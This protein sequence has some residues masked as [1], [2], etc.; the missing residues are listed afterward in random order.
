MYE[1]PESLPFIA[2]EPQKLQPDPVLT[3]TADHG[4]CNCHGFCFTWDSEAHAY[5]AGL[6]GHAIRTHRATVHRQLDRRTVAAKDVILQPRGKFNI[7]S[8]VFAPVFID[9][10]RAKPRLETPEPV[11]AVL[12]AKRVNKGPT[13]QTFINGLGLNALDEFTGTIWTIDVFHASFFL[14]QLD[15][16]VPCFAVAPD[17]RI[18]SNSDA[19][20][21]PNEH[22]SKE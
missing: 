13:G 12:A 21:K 15:P 11:I 5:Y 10:H 9:S 19:I 17:H 22:L 3:D 4:G 18:N 20:H 6:W 7:D 1:S 8:L 14:R 2:L 16:I